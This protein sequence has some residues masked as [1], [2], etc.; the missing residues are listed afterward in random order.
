M[1]SE[2]AKGAVVAPPTSGFVRRLLRFVKRR[3]RRALLWAIRPIVGRLVRADDPGVL[4]VRDLR[5]RLEEIQEAISLREREVVF[6]GR[7]LADLEDGGLSE[8]LAAMERALR[9]RGI[10]E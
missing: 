8:R 3:V 1:S 2:G 5:S 10:L 6:L 7:R 9:D 4:V